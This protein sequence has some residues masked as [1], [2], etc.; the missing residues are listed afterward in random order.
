MCQLKIQLF[1]EI[2]KELKVV[3]SSMK[4]QLLGCVYLASKD[5]VNAVGTTAGSIMKWYNL[6]PNEY[7]TEGCGGALKIRAAYG[8]GGAV[9]DD[10]IYLSS[11]YRLQIISAKEIGKVDDFGDICY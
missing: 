2:D 4:D 9:G 1:N 3:G 11:D 6:T 7:T 10:P 5:L 8:G